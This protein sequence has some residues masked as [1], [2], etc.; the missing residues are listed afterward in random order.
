MKN[1]N[2]FPTL[3][4]LFTMIHLDSNKSQNMKVVAFCKIYNFDSQSFL[5]WSLYLKL[6]FFE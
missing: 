3:P 6:Q 5:I 1:P 4:H 2:F